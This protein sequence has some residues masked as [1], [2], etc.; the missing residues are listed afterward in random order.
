[1][2][3]LEMRQQ[4]WQVNNPAF[5]YISHFWPR[6]TKTLKK[7]IITGN[8]QNDLVSETLPVSISINP[9][10]LTK[11]Q[12]NKQKRTAG[13]GLLCPY[14]TGVFSWVVGV[15]DE[16][17]QHCMAAAQWSN[18][19]NS[20]LWWWGQSF[21][22]QIVV[23]VSQIITE[24]RQL[25]RRLAWKQ[26]LVLKA[27]NTLTRGQTHTHNVNMGLPC[28][29]FSEYRVLTIHLGLSWYCEFRWDADVG[30]FTHAG[31]GGICGQGVFHV[32]SAWGCVPNSRYQFD[33]GQDSWRCDFEGDEVEQVLTRHLI[34]KCDLRRSFKAW[35][36]DL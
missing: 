1:M 9:T 5:W 35:C 13:T 36:E 7:A 32:Y 3:S 27:E 21:E 6:Y 8:F 25:S 14:F 33:G 10:P 29:L 26:R 19:V 18:E 30:A 20:F 16:F 12:T 17:N 31:E 15:V 24:Q 28:F 23:E 34:M 22:K 4:R 2:I 11:K